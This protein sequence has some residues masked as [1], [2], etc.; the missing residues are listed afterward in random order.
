VDNHTEPKKITPKM[1]R[2]SVG[3]RVQT[4]LK[5]GG[6]TF[7]SATTRAADGGVTHTDTWRQGD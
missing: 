1:E 4:G 3:Q 5:A 2:P 7:Y 6:L